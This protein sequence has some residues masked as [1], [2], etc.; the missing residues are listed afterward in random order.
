MNKKIKKIKIAEPIIKVG[1]DKVSFGFGE[2]HNISYKEATKDGKFFIDL[3]N[4]L[5]SLCNL[6]WNGISTSW[7]HGYGYEIMSKTSM[8]KNIAVLMP[9]GMDSLQVFRA[10]GDNHV[11][12]GYRDGN[13]FQ[14]MFIEYQFG[15]IY[16]HG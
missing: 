15:D 11:F 4:R 13:T 5:K 16:N 8:N 3:L 14:V 2:L 1:S 6:G 9:N 7:R 10:S 12:L